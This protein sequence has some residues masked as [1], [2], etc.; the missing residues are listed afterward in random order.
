M[1]KKHNPHICLFQETHGCKDSSQFWA[2]EWGNKC[3]FAHGSTRGQGVAIMLTKTVGNKVREVVRDVN[4]RY[5]IVKLE[6]EEYTYSITNVYAPN[7]DSPNFYTELINEIE[8]LECTFDIVGGDFN[9]ALDPELDRKENVMYNANSREKILSR[10]ED[11]D[12]HDIWRE[13]NPQKRSLTWM[14]PNLERINWSRIDY[15]LLSRGGG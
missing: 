11:R 2:N 6:I 7:D 1:F 5:I 8:K 14:S 15:F 4:G 13:N 10:M 3:L 9:V 12:M